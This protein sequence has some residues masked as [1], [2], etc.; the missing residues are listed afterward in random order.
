MTGYLR[1]FYHTD[2]CISGGHSVIALLALLWS[3]I[4]Y[5]ILPTEWLQEIL[6]CIDERNYE[7]RRYLNAVGFRYIEVLSYKFY[8]N[9]GRAEDY[10]S[11]H[12]RIRYI[13]EF[14]IMKF[15]KSRF[16]YALSCNRPR[17]PEQFWFVVLL[18]RTKF[19]LVIFWGVVHF[20]IIYFLSF[21]C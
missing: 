5:T 2:A 12:R 17:R 7:F 16:H 14:V 9:F 4:I 6:I 18:A 11:L 15:V 21:D 10:R 3:V 8:C 13:E 19:N 20:L 1:I